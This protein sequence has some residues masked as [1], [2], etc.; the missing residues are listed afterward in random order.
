MH[1]IVGY[2]QEAGVV[3]VFVEF[4]QTETEQRVRIVE[5]LSSIIGSLPLLFIGQAP[6][7]ERQFERQVISHIETLD[8]AMREALEKISRNK[9]AS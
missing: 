5:E 6:L 2:L 7:P 4:V 1:E 9:T 8:S 3:V